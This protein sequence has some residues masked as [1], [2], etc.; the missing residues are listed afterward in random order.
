MLN[1]KQM[2]ILSYYALLPGIIKA[3]IWMI[4]GVILLT[5]LLEIT[6]E[7]YTYGNSPNSLGVIITIIVIIFFVIAFFFGRS[8][9]KNAYQNANWK[10]ITERIDAV[11]ISDNARGKEVSLADISKA[12]KSA[13]Q[14]S[15]DQYLNVAFNIFD[16]Y[17]KTMLKR[18][19]FV[20]VPCLLI[21]GSY[22][23]TYIQN[24]NAYEIS[25]AQVSSVMSS[26]SDAFDTY[27]IFY[28]DPYE[29]YSDDYY[30]FMA[31]TDD[32]YIGINVLNDGNIDYIAYSLT[33]DLSIEKEDNL[34]DMQNRLNQ[35]Y[36]GLISANVQID[37]KYLTE[38]I[39][40]DD[41]TTAF[42]EDINDSE[43]SEIRCGKGTMYINFY[44]SADNYD[45]GRLYISIF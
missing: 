16:Y 15:F 33:I 43:Y 11:Y 14:S 30:F 4:P 45:T 26:L 5:F 24:L 32:D 29:S 13:Y 40:G 41:F 34:L 37:D 38:P 9:L 18:V 39:L 36:T 27:E 10:A 19:L 6:N 12:R 2:R 20:V 7:V 28:D 17:P 44:I 23:P 31:Y 22:I 42:L 35:F 1:D 8:A 21:V 3:S 25:C